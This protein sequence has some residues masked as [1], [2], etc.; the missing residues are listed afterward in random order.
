MPA[1]LCIFKGAQ[2]VIWSYL[3]TSSSQ[4]VQN[5]VL[6]GEASKNG[7]SSSCNPCCG[8]NTR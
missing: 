3:H 4:A 5:T 7:I 1:I 2:S 6:Q 8:A